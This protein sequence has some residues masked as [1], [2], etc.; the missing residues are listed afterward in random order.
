MCGREWQAIAAEPL[1]NRTADVSSG[2]IDTPAAVAPVTT[3][4]KPLQPHTPLEGSRTYLY[5]NV[6]NPTRTV[7]YW[8]GCGRDRPAPTTNTT[9]TVDPS[10]RIVCASVIGGPTDMSHTHAAMAASAGNTTP[11]H[12]QLAPLNGAQPSAAGARR[13]LPLFESGAACYRYLF[14]PQDERHSPNMS[15][16]PGVPAPATVACPDTPAKP[17]TPTNWQPSA[18]RRPRRP[19]SPHTHPNRPAPTRKPRTASHHTRRPPTGS[20]PSRQRCYPPPPTE[21]LLRAIRATRASTV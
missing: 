9:V 12:D 5:G 6:N 14:T 1:P 19:G 7:C 15:D 4:A 10:G 16:L 3:K 18:K 2:S 17:V 13:A 8:R 20:R 21:A 11:L